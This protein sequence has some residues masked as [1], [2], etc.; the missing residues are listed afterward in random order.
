MPLPLQRNKGSEVVQYTQQ[1]MGWGCACMKDNTLNSLLSL[2]L[3]LIPV[4]C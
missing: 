1:G 4:S 3:S 2:L